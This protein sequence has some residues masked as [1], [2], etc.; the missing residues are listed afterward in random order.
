MTL[1]PERIAWRLAFVGFL[2]LFPGFV[3]YHLLVMW[4][5]VPPLLAGFFGPVSVALVN[6]A[7]YAFLLFWVMRSGGILG[8]A[9][10]TTLVPIAAKAVITVLPLGLVVVLGL[11]RLAIAAAGIITSFLYIL[12]IWVDFTRDED[13]LPS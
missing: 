2:A 4:L 5:H 3:L 10:L 8:R 9:V 13:V 6:A 1:Y 7:G 12:A 11:D